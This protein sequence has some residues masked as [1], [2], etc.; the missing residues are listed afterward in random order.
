VRVKAVNITH[1]EIVTTEPLEMA[2]KDR[3]SGEIR[4]TRQQYFDS[5]T[6][7]VA[8]ISFVACKFVK[9]FGGTRCSL[10]LYSLASFRCVDI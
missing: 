8:R 9:L 3:S 7:Q 1:S 5:L 2:T 6:I 4:Y 10:I